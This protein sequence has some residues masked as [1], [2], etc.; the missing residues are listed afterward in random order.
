VSPRPVPPGY[1]IPTSARSVQVGL[2]VGRLRLMLFDNYSRVSSAPPINPDNAVY[3]SD[4]FIGNHLLVMAGIYTHPLGPFASTSTVTVSRH[5]L[6]PQ[7]GYWNVYNN[8]DRGYKYAFGSMQK[9]DEQL[10]GSTTRWLTSR[11]DV[12]PCAAASMSSLPSRMRSIDATATSTGGRQQSRGVRRSP[13]ES[14]PADGRRLRSGSVIRKALVCLASLGV[15]LAVSH[16][17]A[18]RAILA[19]MKAAYLFNFM[20]FTEWPAD[21]PRPS[22]VALCVVGDDELRKILQQLAKGAKREVHGPITRIVPL[23]RSAIESVNP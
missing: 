4:A 10:S 17:K 22:L 1:D 16:V 9:F 12:T 3:N 11:S 2:S 5:T 21:R 14:A 13:A 15:V 7:S 8:L 23:A 6:N 18:Q 19:G 20:K